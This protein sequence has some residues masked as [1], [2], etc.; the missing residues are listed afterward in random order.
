L[1]FIRKCG[2][3]LKKINEERKKLEKEWFGEET[4]VI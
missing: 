4:F 3:K 2:N 1:E